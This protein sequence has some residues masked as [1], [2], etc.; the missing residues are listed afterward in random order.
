MSDA[1]A[2]SSDPPVIPERT[3][4]VDAIVARARVLVEDAGWEALSTRI[5]DLA[6]RIGETMLVV[7][8]PASEV[9]LTIVRVC[10]AYGLDPVHVDVTYN[11]ITIAH[12]R[13]GASRCFRRPGN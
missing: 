2:P 6:I 11:S 5:L 1:P 8:A 13:P 3:A 12:S 9:T 4:R 10:G 7:G